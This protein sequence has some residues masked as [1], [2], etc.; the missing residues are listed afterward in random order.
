MPIIVPST[1]STVVYTA[2]DIVRNALTILKVLGQDVTLD[3]DDSQTGLSFLNMLLDGLSNQE[4][5][6]H[7]VV[8]ESFNLTA[9]LNPHTW[10]T[11]GTFNSTRPTEVVEASIRLSSGG[12]DVPLQI[13]SYDVYERER[14]KGLVVN[15]PQIVYIDNAYPLANCWFWPVPNGAIANFQSYKPFTKFSTIN[16]Q[17][18]LPP[19]YMRMLSYGLSVE[20]AP[21]YNLDPPAMALRI[22]EEA[23]RDIKRTN[24]K[25][26]MAKTDPALAALSQT[27]GRYNPY[28]DQRN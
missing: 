27:A 12:V 25:A 21:V 20:L 9:G 7:Q 28:S 4:L 17:V 16:D 6:I 10:G 22:Y 24:Y 11:G 19:G 5:T 26:T 14:I 3:A 13:V 23:M 15:Y 1:T 18:T 2:G 8:R